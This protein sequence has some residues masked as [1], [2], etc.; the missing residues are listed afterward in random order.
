MR[1]GAFA[2]GA[3]S[4]PD[5]LPTGLLDSVLISKCTDYQKI[6]TAY[7]RYAISTVAQNNAAMIPASAIPRPR[8]PFAGFKRT[9]TSAENTR[10]VKRKTVIVIIPKMNSHCTLGIYFIPMTADM[11]VAGPQKIPMTNAP[12]AAPLTGRSSP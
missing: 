3:V 4:W 9:K 5:N 12:K 1:V 10:D 6:F 7:W 8:G 2:V 11:Y